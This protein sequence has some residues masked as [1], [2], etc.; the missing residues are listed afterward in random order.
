MPAARQ[1]AYVGAGAGHALQ[2]SGQ[3]DDWSAITAAR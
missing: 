3:P 1:S 2:P